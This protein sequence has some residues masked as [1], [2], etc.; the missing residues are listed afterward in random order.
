LAVI[1]TLFAGACFA[2]ELNTRETVERD[3]QRLGNVLRNLP[4]DST[5]MS[6]GWD[7]V[8][9]DVK[10]TDSLLAPVVAIIDLSCRCDE[11]TLKANARIAAL[12]QVNGI[13]HELDSLKALMES[14][15]ETNTARSKIKQLEADR[16]HQD[17][18]KAIEGKPKTGKVLVRAFSALQDG[19]WKIY[20]AAYQDIAGGWQALE[21][22]QT[23]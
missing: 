3:I 2:E 21:E 10:K 7:F 20:K 23:D 8:G 13:T 6:K 11:T 18:L 4:R 17:F 9:W 1:L 15:R 5:G 16:K 22:F 19:K 14:S 12:A